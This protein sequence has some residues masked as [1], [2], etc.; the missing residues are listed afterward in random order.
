MLQKHVVWQ[1]KIQ[2]QQR[3]GCGW[4]LRTPSPERRGARRFRRE[5]C[6]HKAAA[7]GDAASVA[8]G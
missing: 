3:S 5:A 4:Q 6:T 7:R 8:N 2:Q 1:Q